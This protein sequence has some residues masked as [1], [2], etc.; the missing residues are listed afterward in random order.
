MK[1]LYY[2]S[3]E[4]PSLQGKFLSP[5]QSKE[6]TIRNEELLTMRLCVFNLRFF[7]IL[8]SGHFASFFL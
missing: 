6:D 2:G 4:R 1:A 5:S 3:D 8:F 7:A